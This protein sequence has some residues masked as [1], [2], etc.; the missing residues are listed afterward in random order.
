MKAIELYKF[1]ITKECKYH[2]TAKQDVV[3]FVKFEDLD[4]FVVLLGYTYVEDHTIECMFKNGY[5][6]FLMNGICEYFNINLEDAF[7]R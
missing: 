5:I 2:H 4:D 7:R 6:G 1:V 3:L